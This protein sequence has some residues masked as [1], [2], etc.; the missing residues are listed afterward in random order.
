MEEIFKQYGPTIIIAIIFVGLFVAIKIVT[1]KDVLGE[2][3]SSG[4][5]AVIKALNSHM[6]T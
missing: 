4:L 3:F 2:L 1:G 6:P 5:E